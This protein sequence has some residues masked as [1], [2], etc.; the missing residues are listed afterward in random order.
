LASRRAKPGSGRKGL[1]LQHR[2]RSWLQI[3][4]RA[5]A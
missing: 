5:S 1:R 3:S 2:T 4:R